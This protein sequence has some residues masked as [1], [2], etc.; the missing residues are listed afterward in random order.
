MK[1]HQYS[2]WSTD[3]TEMT[4]KTPI[5]RLAKRLPMSS[6][7]AL[8]VELDNKVAGGDEQPFADIVHSM[9]EAQLDKRSHTEKLEDAIDPEGKQADTQTQSE[10][11][12][13]KELIEAIEKLERDGRF[14][15]SDI[16]GNRRSFCNSA[17]LPE[18]TVDRLA[19]YRHSLAN[20]SGIVLPETATQESDPVPEKE[21]GPTKEAT[22][23]ELIIK[24]TQ[25][26]SYMKS[27]LE[28]MTDEQIENIIKENEQTA[29]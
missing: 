3:Y 22:R 2:P 6:E 5:R 12:E 9:I 25:V 4:R 29:S 7:L 14:S 20:I 16:T 19:S 26:S 1:Y 13:K 24:A 11:D 15:A 28:K 10:D 21:A 23:A 27:E 18:A 17:I 8:A